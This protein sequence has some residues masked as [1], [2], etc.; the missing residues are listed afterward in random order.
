MKNIES[1][2]PSLSNPLAGVSVYPE[3]IAIE[4]WST[5]DPEVRAYFEGSRPDVWPVLP[6][7][8]QL[9]PQAR[10]A[11]AVF[12]KADEL[13]ADPGYEEALKLADLRVKAAIETRRQQAAEE[14]VNKEIRQG[15]IFPE[16][17]ESKID[18]YAKRFGWVSYEIEDQA[19]LGGLP[20]DSPLY[21]PLQPGSSALGRLTILESLGFNEENVKGSIAFKGMDNYNM[22][23]HGEVL[24]SERFFSKTDDEREMWLAQLLYN[25]K[26]VIATRRSDREKRDEAAD[27]MVVLGGGNRMRLRNTIIDWERRDREREYFLKQAVV[28]N[29]MR[30]DLLRD[31]L[32]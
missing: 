11:L 30:A 3:L 9:N 29:R 7:R 21:E 12:D 23:S 14:R 17:R 22:K 2:P 16:D 8:D 13:R 20:E 10:E 24:G 5:P 27:N 1:T 28:K 15:K 32:S 31:Y 19:L 26:Y 18:Y 6:P 4:P 25:A